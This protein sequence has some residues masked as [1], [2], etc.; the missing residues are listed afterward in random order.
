M[1]CVHLRQ[2]RVDRV[3]HAPSICNALKNVAIVDEVSLGGLGCWG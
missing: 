3:W 1:I 2:E